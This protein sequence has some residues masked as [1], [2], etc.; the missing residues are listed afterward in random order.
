M[1]WPSLRYTYCLE[2]FDLLYILEEQLA[3]GGGGGFKGRFVRL[4]K[5]TAINRAKNIAIYRSTLIPGAQSC[6]QIAYQQ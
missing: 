6:I 1:I 2:A 5:D 4:S 3:Q